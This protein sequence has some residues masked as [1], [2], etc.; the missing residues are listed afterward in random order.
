[1]SIHSLTVAS[2][3]N[4]LEKPQKFCLVGYGLSAEC[5]APHFCDILKG[6]WSDLPGRI[7][8]FHSA[9]HTT[10][11]RGWFEWRKALIRTRLDAPPY[12]ALARL[13]A[14]MRLQVATQCVDGLAGLN[15]VEGVSELY[16]NVFAAR[17]HLCGHSWIADPEVQQPEQCP[18]C[19]GD[20]WPDVAMFGWNP[21]ENV[22]SNWGNRLPAKALLLL[23]GDELDLAPHPKMLVGDMD[24]C[25]IVRVTANGF[26]VTCNNVRSYLPGKE[27][28][29]EMEKRP[30]PGTL[31]KLP[32][33]KSLHRSVLC[34]LWLLEYFKATGSV[35]TSG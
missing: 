22:G 10:I 31:P 21:Q 28:E 9:E 29:R 2:F 26:F 27:I 19:T 20:I 13:Q 23:I 24:G 34:L 15:G 14:V 35:A 6:V 4:H 32:D 1:M 33:Q 12:R 3:L 17:C 8:P 5:H 11:V 16:G 7:N 30:W 25:S 18:H